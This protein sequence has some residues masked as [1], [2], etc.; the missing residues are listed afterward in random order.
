M[1]DGLEIQNSKC[2][3]NFEG[4]YPDEME[5]IPPAKG[6]INSELLCLGIDKSYK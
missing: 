2:D 5:I 1:L 6:F 3:V 4:L